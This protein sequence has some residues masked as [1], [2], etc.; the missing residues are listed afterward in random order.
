MILQVLFEVTKMIYLIQFEWL[1][2]LEMEVLGLDEL[3]QKLKVSLVRKV[4]TDMLLQLEQ[5]L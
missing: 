3:M 5:A 4:K 2:L 1:P